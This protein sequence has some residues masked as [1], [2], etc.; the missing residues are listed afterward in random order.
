MASS[1]S[2]SSFAHPPPQKHEVFISFRGTDTRDTFTSHL[3]A[4]LVH[5]KIQ[6]YMDC[7]LER[8]DKIGPSLLQAIEESKLSLIVFSEN[9]ASSTWCLN[10]L[11]HIL[12]CGKRNGQIV[13]PIFYG[14]DPSQVRKQQG[15]YEDALAELEERFKDNMDKVLMWRNALKEAAD[16]SGFENSKRTGTEADFVEEVAEDVLTK[17]YRALSSDLEDQDQFCSRKISDFKGMPSR[18]SVRGGRRTADAVGCFASC[19]FSAGKA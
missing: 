3:H 11:A 4:A 8:G 19:T 1:S 15:S 7:R 10:E 16:L 13:I 14:I 9:Y 6:T 18:A 17:L 12:E 5:K 2:S